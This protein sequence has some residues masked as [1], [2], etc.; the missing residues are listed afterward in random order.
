MRTIIRAIFNNPELSQAIGDA[1]AQQRRAYNLAVDWLNREPALPLRASAGKGTDGNRSLCGRLTLHKQG[2]PDWAGLR[3]IQDT[4]LGQAHRANERM[5]ADRKKRILSIERTLTELYEQQDSIPRTKKERRDRDRLESRAGRLIRQH[6]RGRRTLAY[7]TRKYGTRTLEIA[8]YAAF[9][10]IDLDTLRWEGYDIKLKKPLPDACAADPALKPSNRVVRSFRFV[11]IRGREFSARTPLEKLRYEIH[12][13]IAEPDPPCLE[14][15][16]IAAPDEIIGVDVG[17]KRNWTASNGQH[18]NIGG[19]YERHK[20]QPRRSQRRARRKP[21][22]SNRR[23]EM[24]RQRRVF[25][26]RRAAEKKRQYHAAAIRIVES[27]CRAV[28]IERLNIKG[29][30]ASAKGGANAHGKNVAQKRSL[31]AAMAAAGLADSRT[32]LAA[33]AQK[34]GIPVLEVLAP[35]SSQACPRCGDRHRAN[36]ETQAVFRCRN[37][38]YQGNADHTAAVIIRNRA[39]WNVRLSCH[40]ETVYREDAPTGWE[41]QPSRQAHQ[42]RLFDLPNKH[43]AA[44][45]AESAFKP[46]RRATSRKAGYGAQGRASEQNRSAAQAHIRLC[47]SPPPV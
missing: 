12:I 3:S 42:L 43:R 18:Y 26:R 2:R 24:E 37:C 7:R 38:G 41:T 46:K 47:D 29:M 31:N 33:Q 22:N 35:G 45:G 15:S 5:A 32:I 4:G 1:A 10:V 39:F 14:E 19:K 34:R 16:E 21:E 28:A 6:D 30:T 8:S 13:A 20:S 11:A 23:K 40:G 9:R 25:L 44:S 27:G 36:R 17:V